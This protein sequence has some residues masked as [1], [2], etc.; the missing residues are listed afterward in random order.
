MI[1]IDEDHYVFMVVYGRGSHTLSRKEIGTRYALAGIRILVDPNDPKDV[2][3]VHALQD[4]IMV[5]QPGGPGRFEVPNWDQASLKKVRDA[6]VVLGETIPDWRRAAGRRKACAVSPRSHGSGPRQ[7]APNLTPVIFLLPHLTPMLTQ[8]ARLLGV[9]ALRLDLQCRKGRLDRKTPNNFA[10]E[11]HAPVQRYAT[12]SKW[13]RRAAL[14]DVSSQRKSLNS[15][16]VR[17]SVVMR[18]SEPDAR[19]RS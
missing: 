5:R 12:A 10:H 9:D 3:Q 17:Y 4:A 19:M 7:I 6:L 13:N 16:R 11:R 1:V 15:A 8:R 18:S 2:A 14:W